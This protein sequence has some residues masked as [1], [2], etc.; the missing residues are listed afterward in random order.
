MRR[1]CVL[2]IVGLLVLP[3][4]VVAQQDPASLVKQARELRKQKQIEAA[5]KLYAQAA[6]RAA[7]AAGENSQP[8]AD[9]LDEHF[10]ML[11]KAGRYAECVPVAERLARVQI[12]RSGKDSIPAAA[13][14][15]RVALAYKLSGRVREAGPLYE[16]SLGV[17]RKLR[18]DSPDTAQLMH[19][20]AA[21]YAATGRGEEAERLYQ[22][23]LKLVADKAGTGHPMY[24]QGQHNLATFYSQEGRNAEAADLFR[25]AL[26][27]KKKTAGPNDPTVAVSLNNLA[28]VLL[29]GGD[30][31]GAEER[32]KE[33]IRIFEAGGYGDHPHAFV[34]R[35]MLAEA[36]RS[37]G[38]PAEAVKLAGETLARLEKAV[39]KDDPAVAGC[40]VRLGHALKDQVK[41]PDAE[42]AYKRAI[43]IREA[44]L[45]AGHPDTVAAW[46]LLADVFRASGQLDDAERLYRKAKVATDARFGKTHPRAAD[47]RR[48]LAVCL[49]EQGEHESAE[50]LL[51]E[52]R[53]SLEGN[54]RAD[55]FALRR[56]DHA[57]AELYR[58]TGRLAAAGPLYAAALKAATDRFGTDH[59]LTSSW[60]YN[61]ALLQV[62]GRKFA[63]ADRLLT[64]SLAG[65]EKTLGPNHPA[66]LASLELLADV[67]QQLGRTAEAEALV[68]DAL[69]RGAGSDPMLVVRLSSNLALR[70]VLAGDAKAAKE[71]ARRSI[72]AVKRV[73]ALYPFDDPLCW[74]ARHN[75]GFVY[76]S[77]GD[78]PGAVAEFDA[79]R[80]AVRRFLAEALPGLSEREQL[81]VLEKFDRTNLHLALNL[82]PA[83]ATDATVAARTAE[84]ALN[85]KAVS[86]EALAAAVRGTGAAD[87][88]P[89]R[90]TLNLRRQAAGIAITPAA[91]GRKRPAD[92]WVPL[93]ALQALL[94]AGAVFIDVVRLDGYRVGLGQLAERQPARYVAWVTGKA[95]ATKVIDLGPAD[96]IDAAVAAARK[97][98]AD[99]PT[100]IR[101]DG[102]PTAEKKLRD[103]AA[104]LSRL[105]LEPLR[106]AAGSVTTW[107]VAP[108]GELWLYPWAALPTADGKYLTESVDVRYVTSGRELL[109]RTPVGTARDCVI[110]ADPDFDA[111]TGRPRTLAVAPSGGR[112]V[113]SLLGRVGRLPGTAVEAKAVAPKLAAL[114]AREPTV[115][116]GD[117]ATEHG[118]KQIVRPRVLMLATHGFYLPPEPKHQST[119]MNWYA[120]LT[121]PLTA[122]DEAVNPLRRS[123]VLLAGCNREPE[124]GGDD[125]VLTGLDVLGLDL[126]GCEL[127]V[128]SACETGLGEVRD[129]EGVGGLR[130]AFLAA[131]AEKVMSTLWQ[132][133][134]LESARLMARCF[135]L[136]A[137]GQPT[138]AALRQAQLEVVRRRRE[139]NAAAHPFFWAAYTMTGR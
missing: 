9:V 33:A 28:G 56:L 83:H 2:V 55:P 128:L 87:R 82:G 50:R 24:G 14:V 58:E 118:V 113:A 115:L 99:A 136:Q 67:K 29:D 70:S 40:L 59:P 39:G 88:P 78:V 94:P 38:R 100:T 129:G 135:D 8:I 1:C 85:G 34:S 71:Y 103:A 48:E 7:S 125:G 98:I 75:A 93:A 31:K 97:A 18:P 104:D 131:G 109:P 66:T 63:D 22:S 121:L 134:D 21:V 49:T 52:A 64:A 122:G 90:A 79:A 37:Q 43:A 4:T 16:H 3:A 114:A 86:H 46:S 107:Y 68:R 77:A 123:G 106:A 26:A 10:E 96:K 116:T 15:N 30:T 105:V 42:A 47:T 19:N 111:G 110:V 117:R 60:A 139:T 41:Y 53:K 12:A 44:K 35:N 73:E 11:F 84:W 102:E 95:G 89:V 54:K 62:A 133:P 108:D 127:V 72:E 80:R 23:G 57:T 27:A 91:N 17:F 132:V 124:S 69:D 51:A 120:A 101:S 76:A 32:L 112:G 130:Q 126:R 137:G 25:Q 74:L 6:D 13:A 81:F 36:Y 20:L 92:P 119:G 138:G 65:R 45:E 61:T 5:S